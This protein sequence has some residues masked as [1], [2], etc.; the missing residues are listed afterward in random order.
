MHSKVWSGT[1]GMVTSEHA[2]LKAAAHSNNTDNAALE[3][4]R[5]FSI[6]KLEMGRWSA[7]QRSIHLFCAGGRQTV[8]GFFAEKRMRCGSARR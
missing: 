4:I 7:A 1:A 3:R 5:E 8:Q 2:Q 6:G